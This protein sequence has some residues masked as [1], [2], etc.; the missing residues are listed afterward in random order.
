M[1]NGNIFIVFLAIVSSCAKIEVYDETTTPETSVT[2]TTCRVSLKQATAF[3]DLYSIRLLNAPLGESSEET[4]SPKER[5]LDNIDCLVEDG[6]T[7]MYSFNYC[8]DGGFL[9]VGANYS[10]FPILAYNSVGSLYFDKIK[11]DNPVSG[12]LEEYKTRIKKGLLESNTA[13]EYYE[14][15]KDLGKDDYEYEV[16]PYNSSDD[17]DT[18]ARRGNSSGKSTIY[19]YTGMEL[20][21]WCQEGGYN[22]CAENNACIGCP[23]ISIG[24][25]MY[26][27]HNRITGDMQYT[28]PCFGYYDAL[29]D[30]SNVSYAPPVA[31][32]LREIADSIPN[33]GWGIGPGYG[34]GAS[35]ANIETGLHKLGYVQ[36][37]AQYY[38]FDV[39]YRNMRFTG[40]NYFGSQTVFNRGILLGDSALQH[41]WF[42]D[43]Y[44]E[45]CYHV[46]KKFL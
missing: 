21:Y 18:K 9:L 32:K 34:S 39:L 17:I 40:Y 14:R 22:Y 38:N 12:F 33:Y 44:Y 8:D 35:R 19:P 41:I 36:A 27:T 11:K 2:P 13:S 23:A 10:Y 1:K 28:N 43:G 15:W 31:Y 46:I 26:D 4:K 7:L 16:I 25:L 45:Q 42:C 5:I 29:Y 37:S 6:D 3:A 30:F 24:M 20:R